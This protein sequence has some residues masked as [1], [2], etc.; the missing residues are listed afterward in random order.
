VAC[1]DPTRAVGSEPGANAIVSDL[2]VDYVAVAWWTHEMCRTADSQHQANSSM[3][4][5]L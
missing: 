3:A 2:W 5:G 4:P 1:I